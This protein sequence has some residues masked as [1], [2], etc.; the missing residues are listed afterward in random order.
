MSQHEDVQDILLD[1]EALAS[2]VRELGAQITKEYAGRQPF[3]VCI[4]KGAAVF[5]ADLCRHIELPVA[6]DFMAI[7]SYG[8]GTSSSGVVRIIKDLDTSIE[9]K[10]V[11]IIED[12]VDSGLTL[13]YLLANLRSRQPASLRTC[14]LLDKPDRREVE[15]SIDYRGFVIPDRFVVGYGLDYSERYR[16]LSYVGVL[17]PEVYR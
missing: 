3:L 2:R 12:I 4:L 13:S 9:G 6:L 5:T 7:S 8:A 15:V 1:G 11:L 14:V 17:K 10:D 16:N